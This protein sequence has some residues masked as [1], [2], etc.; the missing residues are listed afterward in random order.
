MRAGD[1]VPAG[2]L[3]GSVRDLWGDVLE[4]IHAPSDGV[5]LFLTSSP[6]VAAGGLL[7]GFGAELGV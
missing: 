4:E 3:L 2:G 1:E 5:V 6:A 7:L